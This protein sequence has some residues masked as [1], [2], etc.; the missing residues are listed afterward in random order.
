MRNLA[1]IRKNLKKIPKKKARGWINIMIGR[2]LEFSEIVLRENMFA[3]ANGNSYGLCDKMLIVVQKTL[4][5][6]S[7]LPIL[8][9]LISE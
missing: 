8:S 4:S 9:I 7:R 1:K 6:K 2:R 5:P 3:I